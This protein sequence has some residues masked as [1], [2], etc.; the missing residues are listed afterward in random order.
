MASQ[1]F[2]RQVHLINKLP[3]VNILNQ[4]QLLSRPERL[5]TS[6]NTGYN[7]LPAYVLAYESSIYYL[8]CTGTSLR[9][10]LGNESYPKTLA[11]IKK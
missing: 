10:A 7:S 4:I 11:T 3:G 9:L 2:V 1:A 8:S 5:M 6:A